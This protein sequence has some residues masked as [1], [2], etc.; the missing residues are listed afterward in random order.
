MLN[1]GSGLG[2]PTNLQFNISGT[3]ENMISFDASRISPNHANN[4]D[5]STANMKNMV[6]QLVHHNRLDEDLTDPEEQILIKP[7]EIEKN[8]APMSSLLS[9]VH[10][11]SL[12]GRNHKKLAMP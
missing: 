4:L 10:A 3:G 7:Q 5:T 2:K 11:G 9:D 6:G 12:F 1:S 8:N